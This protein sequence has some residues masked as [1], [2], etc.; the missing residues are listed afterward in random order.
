MY[1]VRCAR[2]GSKPGNPRGRDGNDYKPIPLTLRQASFP[3]TRR[4][5]VTAIDVWRK[6]NGTVSFPA[7]STR[8]DFRKRL[9]YVLH[10]PGHKTKT[11]APR[12]F[13]PAR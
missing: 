11:P 9:R 5:I 7:G 12:Y 8:G 3:A 13:C 1:I 10:L 4:R 2:S 6:Q